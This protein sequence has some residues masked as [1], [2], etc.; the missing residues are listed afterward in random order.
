MSGFSLSG[1][2]ASLVVARRDSRDIIASLVGG[3]AILKRACLVHELFRKRE[4]F[5]A[6]VCCSGVNIVLRHSLLDMHAA[7]TPSASALML[8]PAH[9]IVPLPRRM[10]APP[11]RTPIRRKQRHSLLCAPRK[12]FKSARRGALEAMKNLHLEAFCMMS[13]SSEASRS[14]SAAEIDSLEARAAFVEANA[15]LWQNA[16]RTLEEVYPTTKP[17]TRNPEASSASLGLAD[18]SQVGML[19]VH[20]RKPQYTLGAQYTS[21]IRS[22]GAGERDLYP[23]LNPQP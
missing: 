2:P 6:H 8:L 4:S 23:C 20:I 3:A 5:I 21:V 15:L 22:C 7:R 1:S 16:L 14:L 17:Q 18:Y 12:G 11:R 9:L 19:C 13:R 10:P